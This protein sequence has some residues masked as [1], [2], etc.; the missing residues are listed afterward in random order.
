[1]SIPADL[2]DE[3]WR[4]ERTVGDGSAD[5]GMNIRSSTKATANPRAD[6]LRR[7]FQLAQLVQH[8]APNIHWWN[9]ST[10]FSIDRLRRDI[11]WEPD[12]DVASMIGQ[13]WEWFE[14]SG[15]ATRVDAIDWSFEDSILELVGSDA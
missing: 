6:L 11:G 5:V 7:R 13:T 1:V 4:G 15:L 9:R 8:L 10:V 3:L 14:R 12:H 2:M